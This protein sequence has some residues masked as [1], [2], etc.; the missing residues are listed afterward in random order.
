M[1]LLETSR[2]I[3]PLRLRCQTTDNAFDFSGTPTVPRR[4][5]TSAITRS[6]RYAF[7]CFIILRMLLLSTVLEL[8]IQDLFAQTETPPAATPNTGAQALTPQQVFE[9]T[10][11]PIRDDSRQFQVYV[12]NARQLR[13]EDVVLQQR[14]FSCGAAA[15]ATI[16]NKYWGENVSETALLV[17]IARTLTAEELE[18]RI[19]NGLSLTDLKRLLERFG[20]QA[21]LGRLTIDKLRDSKIPLLVGITVN[22]FDHFVVIRGADDDYVYIADPA[23]GKMRVPIADFE[24]QWQKNTVLVVIRPNTKPPTTSVLTV[25][26]EEKR[27]SDINNQFLRNAI[28]SRAFR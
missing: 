11:V 8:S 27:L 23:V 28:T 4:S 10:R 1:D 24:K 14:D 2:L 25:T 15:L 19:N 9:R 12:K 5:T 21:V 13:T 26:E 16:L 17:G 3:V 22:D 18:D 6:P 20:Y 7:G